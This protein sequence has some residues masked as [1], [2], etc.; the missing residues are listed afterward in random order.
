MKKSG[1]FRDSSGL[2]AA[3]FAFIAPALFTLI[4]GISQLGV[5]YFANADLRNAVASSA[6]FASVFPRPTADAVKQRAMQQVAH[7]KAGNITA[8]TVVF[9]TDDRGFQFADIEMK[10]LVPLNFVWAKTAPV[11]L[12]ERRRV[13]IQPAA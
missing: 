2:G 13:Y 3:E 4:I 6:R 1:I 10:Y 11:T 12:T 9:G 8:P 7:M 5:L